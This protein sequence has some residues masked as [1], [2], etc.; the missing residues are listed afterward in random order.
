MSK[1]RKINLNKEEKTYEG[2]IGLIYARVS[3]KRQ[4]TDG[5]GLMSQDSR[6]IKELERIGVPYEKT[7]D[8]RVISSY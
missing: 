1:A 8:A 6:C 3:S 2:R 7:S 5:T 4:E